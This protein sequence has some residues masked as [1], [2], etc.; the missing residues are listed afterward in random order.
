MGKRLIQQASVIATVIITNRPICY[1][2]NRR[3]NT[4]V[5]DVI[6][7]VDISS[8]FASWTR[9]KECLHGRAYPHT[10]ESTV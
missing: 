7:K 2:E 1:G 10:T 8:D 4:T 6:A 9:E 5:Y 3:T